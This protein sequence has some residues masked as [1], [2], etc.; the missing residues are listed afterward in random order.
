MKAHR[1]M[2]GNPSTV[3]AAMNMGVIVLGSVV[4][5]L[6][7]REKVSKVNYIGIALAL[8][9]ILFITLSQANAV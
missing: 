1:A 7:F 2:S 3:F 9:A 4:G 8:A 5:I 6:L